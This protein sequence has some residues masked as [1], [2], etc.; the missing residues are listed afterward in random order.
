MSHGLGGPG[1]GW[2]IS[3]P[4]REDRV[5]RVRHPG[6]E[7]GKKVSG[8]SRANPGMTANHLLGVDRS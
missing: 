8:G 1:R 4:R 3:D 2:Q 7:G 5:P 6:R